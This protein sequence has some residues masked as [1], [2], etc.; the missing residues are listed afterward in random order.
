MNPI[1][2]GGGCLGFFVSV[3]FDNKSF[4]KTGFVNCQEATL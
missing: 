3:F 1:E 2:E 4:W